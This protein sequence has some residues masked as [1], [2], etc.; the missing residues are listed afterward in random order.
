VASYVRRGP[1]GGGY[2]K[3]RGESILALK[4]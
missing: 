1:E 4:A 2:A 3:P